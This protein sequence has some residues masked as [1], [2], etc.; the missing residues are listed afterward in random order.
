MIATV[1]SWPQVWAV[2]GDGAGG[3][4]WAGGYVL[5]GREGRRSGQRKMTKK[6]RACTV[7]VYQL[8]AAWNAADGAAFAARSATM[9]TSS[10]FSAATTLA[11]RAIEAGH[12]MIFGTIYK[13]STVQLQRGEDSLRA[14]RCRA[15]FSAPASAVLRERR[16]A[17]AWKHGQPIV[18]ENVDGKWQ[19]VAMQNTRISEAGGAAVDRH[20]SSIRTRGS[21]Q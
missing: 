6:E 9:P 20:W 10:T 13:G 8:E 5:R 3:L 12:R 15:D 18:A 1:V 11:V 17:R 2:A 4:V 14:S 21:E 19:I 16:A 7:M